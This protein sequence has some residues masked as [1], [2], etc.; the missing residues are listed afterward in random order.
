MDSYKLLLLII[1]ALGLTLDFFIGQIAL[2][3]EKNFELS[4]AIKIV[5][6]IMV[7]GV[8]VLW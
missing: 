6:V 3:N 1:C 7:I 8:I 2:R 4:I 5:E